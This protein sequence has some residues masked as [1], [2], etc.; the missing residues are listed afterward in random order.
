MLYGMC[1][2][3]LSGQRHYDFGLRNILSVLRSAGD[4]LRRASAAAAA[5]A[6]RLGAVAGGLAG[7]RGSSRSRTASPSRGGAGSGADGKARGSPSAAAAA[8]DEEVV[9]LRCVRDINISKLVRDDVPVFLSLLDDIF[10]GKSANS[11]A[12]GNAA[13]QEAMVQICKDTQKA[14]SEGFLHKCTQIYDTKVVRHGIMVVGPAMGGK[15][16]ALNT[17]LAA[18]TVVERRHREVRMNPKAITAGQMFGEMDPVTGDWTDGIFSYLWRRTNKEMSY[19]VWLVCDGPVDTL[20]IESLNTVLDDNKLLTLANGD[21]IQMNPTLKMCFEVENLANASPA[22]VSR[23][24]IIYV[25]L[26]DVGWYPLFFSEISKLV[27]ERKWNSTVANIVLELG[28]LHLENLFKDVVQGARS[29][30]GISLQHY[31]TTFIQIIQPILEAACI[32][33]KNPKGPSAYEEDGGG[34]C[35]ESVR[36]APR[37]AFR[38]A[39]I[40]VSYTHLRAHETP[41]H[42]V[43]RLL[44]EKKKKKYDN[45]KYSSKYE[46]YNTES[47]R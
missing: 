33:F 43:C 30:L 39:S 35:T 47:N 37:R 5:E 7:T 26:E 36:Q 4:L 45:N 38:R 23:A 34:R 46:V 14:P 24:G 15:T 44:L 8:C 25:S 2:Q 6:E 10:P 9:F 31:I 1:E 22:T 11:A 40:S 21:R 19:T 20:W 42:L 32:A 13:L 18:L 41:E 16:T 29:Y 17:L 3:Q 28:K 27:S 12:A